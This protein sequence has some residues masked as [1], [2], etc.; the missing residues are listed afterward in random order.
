[1]IA[2]DSVMA[3]YKIY[4]NFIIWVIPIGYDII[5]TWDYYIVTQQITF[6]F[7]RK[8]KDEVLLN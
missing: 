8:S 5:S 1:M 3:F 4:V 6:K 2:F 7:E